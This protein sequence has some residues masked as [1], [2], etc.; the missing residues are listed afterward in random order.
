MLILN[1][2]LITFGSPKAFKGCDKR[3]MNGV[4]A[5]LDGDQTEKWNK[6]EELNVPFFLYQCLYDS[7]SD[8][9]IVNDFQNSFLS[10]W[11]SARY[12][13][14]H[15]F[16]NLHGKIHESNLSFISAV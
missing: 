16:E 10:K 11:L 15:L 3:W 4:G 9:S 1:L 7:C 8:S 12:N 2:R 14:L 5:S 6:L 13:S